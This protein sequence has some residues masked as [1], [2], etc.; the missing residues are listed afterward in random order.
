MK[1]TKTL[2]TILIITALLIPQQPGSMESIQQWSQ[3]LGKMQKNISQ[4]L[5]EQDSFNINL[6]DE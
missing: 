5:D 6:P 2:L 4:D 3:L 1:I